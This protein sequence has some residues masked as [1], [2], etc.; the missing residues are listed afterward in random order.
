MT[1]K[2]YLLDATSLR[3]D[4]NMGNL[5]FTPSS[6]A[7]H[8]SETG[9]A[10]YGFLTSRLGVA[11]LMGAVIAAPSRPPFWHPS[12]SSPSSSATRRS[13]TT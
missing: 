11:L 5:D 13:P 1:K 10:I 6:H 9:K 12:R 8:E 3:T 7:P 4:P 2:T